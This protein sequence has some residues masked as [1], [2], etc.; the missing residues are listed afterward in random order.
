MIEFLRRIAAHRLAWGLLAASALFL[1]LCALFFQHV[2]GLSPCVMCVYERL[3]TL[4]VL[5]AGLLG[6]VAPDKWYVRWSAMLLWG[7]SAF[8]GFQLAL[9][10]VDYQ[11]N[12]SPF[13]VCSPFADFPSWAPLDQWLPWLFMPEGDCAQITWQFFGYSMPQW[14]VVIFAAY[15]LVF[16][17]VAIGNLVKGRCCS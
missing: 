17:V 14:L 4:G 5:A 9:K 15:L 8:R 7:Y 13:N 10:H 11:V 3:A 12:P 16:T 1:E 6:M 2:L